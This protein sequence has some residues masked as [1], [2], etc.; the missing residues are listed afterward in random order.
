MIRNQNL[1]SDQ[2][3]LTVNIPQGWLFNQNLK[4]CWL[5]WDNRPSCSHLLHIFP[6]WA[7][8]KHEQSRV[9]EVSHKSTWCGGS[10]QIP[11]SMFFFYPHLFSSSVLSPLQLLYNRLT[12][13]ADFCEVRPNSFNCPI[14]IFHFSHNQQQRTHSASLYYLA[15]DENKELWKLIQRKLLF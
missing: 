7:E 3:S 10:C 6:L 11:D 9:Y 5:I 13:E 1:T 8:K 14:N 2:S 15:C 12:G 4:E